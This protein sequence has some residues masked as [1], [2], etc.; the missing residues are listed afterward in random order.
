MRASSKRATVG[1]PSSGAS[2]HLLPQAGEG[3]RD[4]VVHRKLQMRFPREEGVVGPLEFRLSSHL[5]PMGEIAEHRHGRACPGHPRGDA[6]SGPREEAENVR[7]SPVARRRR[8]AGGPSRRRAWVAA[9]FFL[10]QN[11]I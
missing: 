2:R 8:Y 10:R 6:G 11:H 3:F 7:L 4:L 5:I 9:T 1:K